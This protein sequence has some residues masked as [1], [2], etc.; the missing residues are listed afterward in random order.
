M[1]SGPVLSVVPCCVALRPNVVYCTI[2]VHSGATWAWCCVLYRAVVRSTPV[3]P[4]AGAGSPCGL[5]D[6]QPTAAEWLQ[7]VSKT[8]STSHQR[9][10]Y[11]LRHEEHHTYTHARTHTGSENVCPGNPGEPVK[12]GGATYLSA[13]L[14]GF[15][16]SMTITCLLQNMDVDRAMPRLEPVALATSTNSG[17]DAV[18][19]ESE[20]SRDRCVIQK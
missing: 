15:T 10:G 12:V 14:A 18:A 13:M 5:S 16:L 4:G 17:P 11:D 8:P 2:L 20:T 6:R 7:P 1:Y 3:G 9:R 19:T